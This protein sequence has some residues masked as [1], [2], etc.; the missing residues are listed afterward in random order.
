MS[1]HCKLICKQSFDYPSDYLNKLLSEHYQRKFNL[2]LKKFSDGVRKRRLVPHQTDVDKFFRRLSEK[3]IH[4]IF[5]N[6]LNRLNQEIR[7]WTI[8]GSKMRLLV[9]N[10]KYPSY[11]K[12]QPPIEV[13]TY[14]QPVLVNRGCFKAWHFKDMG[15]LYF[16]NSICFNKSSIVQNTLES[17]QNG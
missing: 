5:G 10:T 4:F 11:L 12:L 13:E 8:R 3:D 6:I 9:D 14:K 17:P 16:P 2:K 7:R 15:W 1:K